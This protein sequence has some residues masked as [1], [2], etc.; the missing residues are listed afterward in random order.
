MLLAGGDLAGAIAKFKEANKRGPR[1][2]DSLEGWGEALMAQ[3]DL[4]GAV[5]KFSQANEYAPKWD[6][7]HLKWGE[8]LSGQGKTAEAR[9]QFAQAAA[10]DL[11]PAERAELQGVTRKRTQ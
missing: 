4:K 7:V 1:F 9:A 5:A 8:A 3:G 6:R 10:L 2:A 11:T